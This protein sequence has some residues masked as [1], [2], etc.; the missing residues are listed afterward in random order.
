MPKIVNIIGQRFERLLI[1][2]EHTERTPNGHKKYVC[3]CDCG[4]IHITSGESIRRG[5]SKSC[6]C[7][8]KEYIPSNYN[9][10]RIN[11]IF[12]DLYNSTVNKRSKSKGWVE[13]INFDRFK[14]LVKSNCSY[15]GIEPI[16]KIEDRAVNS[17]EVIFVN[18][19]DRIDSSL[20][21]TKENSV[22][23]C[24]HCNT[25]KNTMSVEKFKNWINRIYNHLF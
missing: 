9:N 22:S 19:V 13:V 8:R 18:S 23:C 6:G 25:A 17:D 5:S 15:C 7:L 11:Q 20:G 12:K 10:N 14:I 24:K 2:K 16:S 4:N 21:Y 3:K 1:L